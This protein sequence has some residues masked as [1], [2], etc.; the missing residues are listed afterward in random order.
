VSRVPIYSGNAAINPEYYGNSIGQAE[1]AMERRSALEGGLRDSRAA[2]ETMSQVVQQ[3]SHVFT[4]Q[5][6][7]DR[8]Q[9]AEESGAAMD[10]LAPLVASG[11]ADADTVRKVLS[12]TISNTLEE[13][14]NRAA[15]ER[16]LGDIFRLYEKG[17][18]NEQ[19]ALGA[20]ADAK[21]H[22][23]NVV[24]STK[25]FAQHSGLEQEYARQRAVA[26]QEFAEA[27][28]VPVKYTRWNDE[29]NSPDFDTRA[30]QMDSAMAKLQQLQ[31]K[32]VEE[33]Q[34]LQLEAVKQRDQ[35]GDREYETTKEWYNN[36][37]AMAEGNDK[38]AEA[39]RL[40][41]EFGQVIQSRKTSMQGFQQQ[42]EKIQR[43]PT[44]TRTVQFAT[45]EQLGLTVGPA[46]KTEFKSKDEAIAAAGAGQLTAGDYF[47]VGNVT[48]RINANGDAA[49]VR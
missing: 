47:K 13:Q 16:D 4:A 29:N 46:I 5:Q 3:G 35:A 27:N 30:L 19:Q 43:G 36:E 20:V 7:Q 15:A 21:K 48:Y 33:R 10:A 14:R 17:G 23:G 37:I 18:I 24:Y 12:G 1:L 9:I 25:A 28:G 26:R 42:T 39:L 22:Y 11:L 44:T 41:Q 49:P 34:R 40:R 31:S 2:L 32:P 8:A 6:R 38:P 45:P